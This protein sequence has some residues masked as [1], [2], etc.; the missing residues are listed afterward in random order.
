MSPTKS[1]PGGCV[2]ALFGLGAWAYAGFALWI[3]GR[4]W[5]KHLLSKHL[6]FLGSTAALAIIAGF[7]L[8]VV[9][10]RLAMRVDRDYDPNDPNEPSLKF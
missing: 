3:G 9:G 1:V 7:V 8:V 6:V 4:L 2:V 5:K 10:Y